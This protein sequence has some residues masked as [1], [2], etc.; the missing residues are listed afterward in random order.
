M[1]SLHD[2]TNVSPLLSTHV[3]VH[4]PVQTIIEL[5]FPYS[6]D[7]HN[8]IK[9]PISLKLQKAPPYQLNAFFPFALRFFKIILP[10]R[11]R[12]RARNP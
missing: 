4:L 9:T 11:V 5:Y 2:E 1:Y 8:P 12:N 3:L 6:T 10:E 7:P